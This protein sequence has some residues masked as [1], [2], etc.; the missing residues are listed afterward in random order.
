LVELLVVIGI[1]ALLISILLPA[2]SKARSQAQ[3]TA[4]AAKLQ[5]IMVAAQNH[6]ND[7]QDY[8]PLCGVIPAVQPE[9]SIGDLY[10]VKYDYLSFNVGSI[11]RPIAPITQALAVEMSNKTQILVPSNS[12][13]IASM[14]DPTSYGRNFTCPAQGNGPADLLVG[15]RTSAA[16]WGLI[17]TD[18]NYSGSPGSF[19]EP[20]SYIWN[21]AVLGVPYGGVYRLSGHG[22]EIRQPAST[23]FCCDGSAPYS[24]TAG[25]LPR[26]A[27]T[28]VD[29]NITSYTISLATVYNTTSSMSSTLFDAWVG[30]TPVAA[31]GQGTVAAPTNVYDK[32][33]H[34]GKINIAFCDGHVETKLIPRSRSDSEGFWQ[35]FLLA[36]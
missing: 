16:F 5:Q 7:H 2:L 12:A 34:N 24:T 36:R 18:D 13:G 33:R 19:C 20:Q 26:P 21:E 25:P 32:F 6:R 9:T 10:A 3:L 17:I 22:S 14:M 35:V 23:M 8:Y 15:Q 29:P 4:C 1:I 27:L 28:G 31:P 11:T 30:N